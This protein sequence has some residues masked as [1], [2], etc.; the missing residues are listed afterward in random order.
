MG[1]GNPLV[2]YD[3][4]ESEQ[5]TKAAARANETKARYG[6]RDANE[7]QTNAG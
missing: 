5:I 1:I 3:E 2:H 4:S 7:K 6:A